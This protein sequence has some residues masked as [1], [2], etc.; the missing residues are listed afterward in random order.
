VDLTYQVQDL[1]NNPADLVDIA[2][3]KHRA[4]DVL[5]N[6]KHPMLIV[7]Q[8][9]LARP[10]GAAILEAAAQIARNTGMIGPAGEGGWN[11]F[12]VLHTAAARVG[13]LD[14]GFLPQKGGKDT[15]AI[16]DAASRGDI[17]FVYLLG[18]DEIDMKK[19]GK[20]FVVYQGS[21]GD[22]GAHR[23]DVI[24]PGAAYT[25]QNG[26]YV[27]TEGR[28]QLARRATFPPGDAREDW[29][30]LRALSDV[31]G[32]RLPYDDMGALRQAMLKDAPHFAQTDSAPAN[33]G[34]DASIWT[35][36]GA[37]GTIAKMPFEYP[38]KDFYL[39]NPIARASHVMAECSSLFVKPRLGAAAE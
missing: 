19:L 5:K 29:T 13:A 31:V 6:A 23:A 35:A 16:L 12:N 8:G 14:L 24:L 1:D 17:D 20:A 33:P 11:G 26:T 4:F 21:H 18:A 10:D 37:A 32:K 25:E 39:T 9:A 30:I 22:A 7:G 34:A 28:V 15:I 27:N 38:V 2:A 36:I 3:G